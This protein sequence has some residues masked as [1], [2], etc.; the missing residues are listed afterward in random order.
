MHN[1]FVP[2]FY[3]HLVTQAGIIVNNWRHK[4]DIARK[5]KNDG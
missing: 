4:E 3:Y 5:N 2:G 1:L